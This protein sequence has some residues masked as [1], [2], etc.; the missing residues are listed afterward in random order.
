MLVNNI[1]IKGCPLPQNITL[2][3]RLTGLVGKTVTVVTPGFPQLTETTGTLSRLTASSF[4]VGKLQVFF[5]TSF[6]V[7]LMSVAKQLKPYEVTVTAEE[8]GSLRGQLIRVGKN[9]VEFIQVPGNRV[10]T[11]FPLNM[12]TEAAC[13][14]ERKE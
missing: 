6:Y 12:F 1:N 13:S 10:P 2:R 3:Q 7:V 9:F 14:P 8:M 4:T 5:N 11:L